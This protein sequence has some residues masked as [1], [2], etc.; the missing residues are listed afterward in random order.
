MDS[1]HRIH[2][3]SPTEECF[4]QP[5]WWCTHTWEAEAG[6]SARPATLVHKMGP[7]QTR[8]L[9]RKTLSGKTRKKRML[10]THW[11]RCNLKVHFKFKFLFLKLMKRMETETP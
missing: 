6:V 5:T 10:H 4:T 7:G 1:V 9:H 2:V 8:L 11:D 3:R